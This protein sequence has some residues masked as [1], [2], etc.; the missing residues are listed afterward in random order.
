MRALR[1]TNLA[2]LAALR[3]GAY[4]E[5]YRAAA[6]RAKARAG[7]VLVLTEWTDNGSHR[8]WCRV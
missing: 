6:I 3:I 4:R 8:V 2:D 7:R 5:M 1:R